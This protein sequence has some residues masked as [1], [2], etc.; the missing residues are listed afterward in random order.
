MG[1]RVR[2]VNQLIKTEVGRFIETNLSRDLG[3]LTI[4]AVETTPDLRNATVW[5]SYLGDKFSSIERE[6]KGLTAEVNRLLV[7]RMNSKIV[8]RI[9]FRQDF[10]GDYAQK[11]SKL[12]DESLDGNKEDSGFNKE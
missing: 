6:L 11:I 3:M 1:E 7:A 9:K 4:T 8:P 12:I 5:Y 2:T 10:S